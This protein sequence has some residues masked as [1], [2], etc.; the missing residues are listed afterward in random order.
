M[1][2]AVA[3][4]ASSMPNSSPAK[5]CSS[6]VA[7]SYKASAA[8]CTILAP[9]SLTEWSAGTDGNNSRC[10]RAPLLRSG[11]DPADLLADVFELEDVETALGSWM[12]KAGGRDPGR[13]RDGLKTRVGHGSGAGRRRANREIRSA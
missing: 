1:G 9:P 12:R 7:R 3:Y 4:M 10:G 2:A 13:R 11:P 6:I 8:R 5:W